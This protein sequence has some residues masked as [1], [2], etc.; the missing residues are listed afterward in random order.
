VAFFAPLRS[1]RETSG[2]AGFHA[3]TA[4]PC[5]RNKEAKGIEFISRG[6]RYGMADAVLEQTWRSLLLCVLCVKPAGH[7]IKKPSRST[8][9]LCNV[10]V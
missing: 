2:T 9:W 1:L 3:K 4:R 7:A 8:G 5:H 10:S 6:A